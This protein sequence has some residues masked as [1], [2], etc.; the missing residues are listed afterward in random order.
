M[1]EWKWKI[2]PTSPGRQ[3]LHLTLA[4]IFTVD[5]EPTK[6]AIRTFDKTIE[7]QIT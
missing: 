3:H 6:R 4:A 2:K 5:G 1:T 7:V